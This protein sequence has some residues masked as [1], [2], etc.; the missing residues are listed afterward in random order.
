MSCKQGFANTI[1]SHTPHLSF[2]NMTACESYG[3]TWGCD[4]DCPTYIEGKC[5]IQEEN[6]KI[7]KEQ[8][9]DN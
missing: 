8:P 3:M 4:P 7:F 6:A 1:N 9:H 5:E 2:P